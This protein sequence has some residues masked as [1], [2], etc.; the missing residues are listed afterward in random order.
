MSSTWI[1]ITLFCLPILL[2]VFV[3]LYLVG[4][5]IFGIIGFLLQLAI[6]YYCIGPDNPFYPR[7]KSGNAHPTIEEIGSY[8]VE[9]NGQVFAGIFW[10]IILGPIALLAYRL[11]YLSKFR[12][13]VATDATILSNLLDWIPA[14]IT[15]LLYLFVG[16]YQAGVNT[17]TKL[18]FTGPEHNATL[19]KECGIKAIATDS[20]SLTL[21]VVETHIE[22]T[23]VLLLA[24]IAIFT[25]ASWM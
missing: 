16:H 25:I 3:I 1:R 8:F 12:P 5:W 21:P 7:V 10:Y 13:T 24:L 18:F 6:F 19:L 15:A 20:E 22:H 14:R 2:A 4:S 23:M 9:V 17:Y 11:V